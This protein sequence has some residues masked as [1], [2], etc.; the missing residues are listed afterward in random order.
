[1]VEN[2]TFAWGHD[3]DDSKPILKGINLSVSDGSLFAV[4]GNVGAGKSSLCSAILGE[5]EKQS[6][7]VNVKVS[8]RLMICNYSYFNKIHTG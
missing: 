6:G 3:E 1:M 7:R 4:V 2:G 5:M 8:R